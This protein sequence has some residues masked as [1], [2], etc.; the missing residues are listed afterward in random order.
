VFGRQR[1]TDL[2]NTDFL[3]HD[4][5]FSH[6][7]FTLQSGKPRAEKRIP[8]LINERREPLGYSSK[9]N[10][11]VVLYDLIVSPA[12]DVAYDAPQY[13]PRRDRRG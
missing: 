10:K 5:L 12:R 2:K 13:P 1:R 7:K 11:G 6:V 8:A 3:F 9:I 4:F